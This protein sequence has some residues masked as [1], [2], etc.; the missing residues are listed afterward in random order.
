M[1]LLSCF[2]ILGAGSFSLSSIIA[3]F[4]FKSTGIVVSAG[5]FSEGKT[6]KPVELMLIYGLFNGVD[7]DL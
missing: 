4:P 1:C 7:S 3:F 5:L 2:G 6:K